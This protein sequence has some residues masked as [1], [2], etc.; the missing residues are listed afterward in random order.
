VVSTSSEL[1]IFNDG[2]LTKEKLDRLFEELETDLIAEGAYLELQDGQLHLQVRLHDRS[3]GVTTVTEVGSANDHFQL[4][5]EATRR[6]RT[7]A[8]FEEA[9]TEGATPEKVEDS[10]ESAPD[11]D[12]DES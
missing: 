5:N 2:E 11:P 9:P 8:G 12:R 10:G 3:G 1:G 4:L 6:L 7:I